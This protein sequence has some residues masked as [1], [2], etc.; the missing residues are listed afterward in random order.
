MIVLERERNIKS[1]IR[2][3]YSVDVTGMHKIGGFAIGDYCNSSTV[4]EGGSSVIVPLAGSSTSISGIAKAVDDKFEFTCDSDSYTSSLA[5]TG[6][7]PSHLCKTK[8]AAGG[9]WGALAGLCYSTLSFLTSIMQ[10]M[11]DSF[12]NSYCIFL[13]VRFRSPSILKNPLSLEI[14]YSVNSSSEAESD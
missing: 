3:K 5:E 13:F 12:I 1:R 8:D 4:I 14:A 2:R 10:M 6:Q 11:L 7:K 9:Q